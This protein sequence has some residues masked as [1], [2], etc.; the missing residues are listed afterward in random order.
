MNEWM[1]AQLVSKTLSGTGGGGSLV[2][3]SPDFQVRTA[4]IAGVIPTLRTLAAD[5]AMRQDFDLDSVE[6]LRMAVDEACGLLVPAS[7]DGELHCD[8]TVSPE[9]MVIKVSIHAT[10]PSVLEEDSMSWQLLTALTTTA[11]RSVTKT[12]SQTHEL[13]IEITRRCGTTS[14]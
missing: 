12:G 13:S 9:Q 2:S 5:L 1:E 14:L 11:Q 7:S 10:D 6:D 4:A 3:T 8:F